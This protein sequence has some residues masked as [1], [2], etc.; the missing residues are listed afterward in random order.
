M[1]TGNCLKP[2]TWAGPGTLVEIGPVRLVSTHMGV[3]VM[4]RFAK[5]VFGG[6]VLSCLIGTPALALGPV[7]GEVG[8]VWWAN[9]Y[10][11]SSGDSSIS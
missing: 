4:T 7:D 5:T 3:V 9:D 1:G 8:A 2:P 11:V 6:L 10:K